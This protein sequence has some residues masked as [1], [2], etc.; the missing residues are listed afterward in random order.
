MLRLRSAPQSG[1]PPGHPCHQRGAARRA[2]GGHL[3]YRVPPD[4]AGVRL[5]VRPSLRVLH[6]V[7]RPPVRRPRNEPSVRVA[8]RRPGGRH[9]PGAFQDHYLPHRQRQLRDGHPE[10]QVHRHLHGFH[11]AG[12]HDHGYPL[13]QRRLQRDSL[14]YEEGASDARRDDHRHEQEERLPGPFGREFRRP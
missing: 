9:R 7:P 3:R 5:Y 4:H 6:Q 2:A 12:G 10:R 1:P 8:P 11:P 14:Y 13:R